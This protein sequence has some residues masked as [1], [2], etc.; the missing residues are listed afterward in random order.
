[1]ISVVFC[2]VDA[3]P[4]LRV[5]P[6]TLPGFQRLVGG[7]I[8]H[9][10]MGGRVGLYC[11]DDGRRL[12]R[13]NR[14]CPRLGVLFGPFFLSAGDEGGRNVSLSP[15]EADEWLSTVASWP[16]ARRT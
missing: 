13:P 8:E 14:L 3:D 15:E 4:E 5:V 10:H 9:W 2:A 16:Q 6:G 7:Y 1:V 11:H 12:H